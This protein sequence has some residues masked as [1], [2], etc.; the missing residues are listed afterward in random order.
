MN[1]NEVKEYQKNYWPKWYVKNKEPRAKY[2]KQWK[3][4]NPNWVVNYNHQYYLDHRGKDVQK[5]KSKNF[6]EFLHLLLTRP[7]K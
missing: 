2:N 7:K 1:K 6:F 5:K 4:D 3:K